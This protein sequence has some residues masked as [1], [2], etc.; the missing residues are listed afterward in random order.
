LVNPTVWSNGVSPECRAAGV[1]SN[2][3]CHA[4]CGEMTASIL[5]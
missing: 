5:G 2:I 3:R 4:G 1:E